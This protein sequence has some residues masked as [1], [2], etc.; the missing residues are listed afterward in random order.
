MNNTTVSLLAQV[1]A[2]V[3]CIEGMKAENQERLSKGLSIAYGEKQFDERA[4][5]LTHLAEVA[6]NLT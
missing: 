6:K 4:D 1:Y 5:N 2:E 3:A